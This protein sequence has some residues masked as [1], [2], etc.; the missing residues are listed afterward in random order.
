LIGLAEPGATFPLDEKRGNRGMDKKLQSGQIVRFELLET[1]SHV[2]T[3]LPPGEAGQKVIEV[4]VDY[5][6]LDDPAAGLKR[7]IPA[8]CIKSIISHE[9]SEP[10][11][12]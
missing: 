4:G 5:V 12:A 11:A 3:I 9:D 8:H 2:F 6:L 7:R 10:Q 1:G